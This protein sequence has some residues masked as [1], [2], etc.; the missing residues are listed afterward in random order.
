MASSSA[1]GD[2]KSEKT[3]LILGASRGIGFEFVEQLLA[4]GNR[5]IATVRGDTST[6][7]PNQKDRCT[8]LNCDVAKEDSINV[9]TI[10]ST[11]SQWLSIIL[12]TCCPR[13]S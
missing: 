4:R 11:F 6:F 12:T 13:H 7:W 3:W 9:R 5:V 10:H 2:I 8:V 1:P